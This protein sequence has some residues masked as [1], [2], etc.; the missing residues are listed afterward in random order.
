MSF[1]GQTVGLVLGIGG[2]TGAKN[3]TQIRPDQLIVAENVTFEDTTIRKEGGASKYNSTAISGAP[4]IY[5]GWDWAYDGATRRMVVYTSDG[6]LLRDDGAGDFTA[7]TLKSGLTTGADVPGVFVEG[8]AE[9]A[10]NNKKLFFFN[11]ADAVQ[12]LSGNGATTGDLATPPADWTGSAQPTGGVTHEG[13]MWGF[14]NSNDPHRLYYSTPADHED[15]TGSGS[16]SLSV[17]PGESDEIAWAVSFKGVLI[18]AKHPRGIYAVDTSNSDVSLWRTTK[19]TESIGGVGPLAVVKVEN[20]VVF[21]DDTANVHALSGVQEFGDFGS[22]SLADRSFFSTYLR[23]E[24]NTT[25][26]ARTQAVFYAAK[27][28]AMFAMPGIGATTNTRVLVIDYNRVD[29][30]RFRL[31]TRDTAEALWLVEGSDHLL[32][33]FHGD[34][35]GFVWEMDT[36]SRTKDGSGFQGKFQTP[37]LDFSFVED[38]LGSVNKSWSFLELA[39]EPVGNYN[40]A[41]DVYLDDTYSETINFNMG[42]SGATLGSLVLGTDALAGGQILNKR[43]RLRGR[44]RRISLVGRNSGA[45]QSFAVA[46][47]YFG[48]TVSDTEALG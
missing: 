48:F 11:G 10:A 20:D 26:L 15:F 39:V 41:V 25:N 8:G 37:H 2:Q 17:Y 34:D 1:R 14:G 16:G 29:R 12:V 43:K 45:G 36:E 6:D 19:I 30:E 33:P 42:S 4:A 22:R 18:V 13:R 23:E 31:S 24:L 44:S 47:F 27:R 5:G 9:V 35:A 28:Q 21:I 3:Q 46:K 40:M 32:K 7:T 38:A